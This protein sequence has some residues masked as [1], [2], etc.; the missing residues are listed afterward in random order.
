MRWVGKNRF[1]LEDLLLRNK[2]NGMP[3]VV[4]RFAI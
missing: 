2:Q 3:Q 1:N 4:A